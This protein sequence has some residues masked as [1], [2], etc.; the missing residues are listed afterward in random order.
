MIGGVKM[1]CALV[2]DIHGNIYALDA[3]LKDAISQNIDRIIFLGDYCVGIPAPNKSIESMRRIEL[4][5]HYIEGNEDEGL[6]NLSKQSAISLTD[7]QFAMTY[8]TYNELSDN[9]IDFLMG[10]QKTMRIFSET[11]T[12]IHAFHK[13]DMFFRGT[14]VT[15]LEAR[16]YYTD[17]KAG[18]YT[19][20]TFLSF[21]QH[22]LISDA[23]LLK[24]L[25]ALSDGVYAFGHSHIQWS[26]A[27]GNKLLISPGSCGAPLDL[28]PGAPYAVLEYSD[29][30]WNVELRRIQYDTDNVIKLIADSRLECSARVWASLVGMEVLTAH[31]QAVPFL[32]YAEKYAKSINDCCRPFSK[33]TWFNAFKCWVELNNADYKSNITKM[34]QL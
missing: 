1:R 7:G 3:V 16:Q 17:V 22:S 5:A 21:V 25:D 29:R 6:L 11:S 2:S 19:N 15:T 9:N 31:E 28:Q 20:Q 32:E 14:F 12:S 26:C 34:V 24:M 33:N 27:V 10:L 23:P 8:W 18:K 13:P 30:K 4:P